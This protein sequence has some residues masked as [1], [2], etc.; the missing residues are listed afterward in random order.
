[1]A[2][3]VKDITEESEKI[4]KVKKIVRKRAQKLEEKDLIQTPIAKGCSKTFALNTLKNILLTIF[5]ILKS[6]DLNS[7]PALTILLLPQPFLLL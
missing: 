7:L 1:M 5:G 6:F 3:V 2:T 4:I